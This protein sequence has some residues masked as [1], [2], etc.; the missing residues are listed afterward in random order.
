M[1]N[2]ASLL[3][4]EI[5]RLARKEVR[6][7]LAALRKASAAHRRQIAALKREVAALQGKAKALAKQAGRKAEA[8][9]AGKKAR[10]TAKGFRSM[11]AKLGLSAAELA[12]LLGVS[13]QSIYNWEHEKAVPR[14]SQVEAIAA[15]RRIGKREANQRLHS[16]TV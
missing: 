4:A 3:K 1:P 6:S 12:K 15:L 10:F 9:E 16:S 14:Q 7:E 2:V 8:E 5:T 11:R 13:Q